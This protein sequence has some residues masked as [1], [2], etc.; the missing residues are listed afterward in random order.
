M[1]EFDLN[2]LSREMPYSVPDNFFETFPS[3]TLERIN[4]LPTHGV[5]TMP[6][7]RLKRLVAGVMS[8]A[9][10]VI[11]ALGLSGVLGSSSELSLEDQFLIVD[12]S[13]LNNFINGLSD[14]QLEQLSSGAEEVDFYNYYY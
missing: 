6:P 13:E 8:A 3:N 2:N 9:A 1:K 4:A 14:E 5:H 11:V 10:V 12:N 7:R